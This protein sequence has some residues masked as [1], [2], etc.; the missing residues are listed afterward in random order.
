[1]AEIR[2]LQS[3][4]TSDGRKIVGIIPYNSD[5]NVISERGRKF[6]E[7]I[8]PGAFNRSLEQPPLGDITAHYTHNEEAMPPLGRTS[9]GTLRLSGN[10]EI[11]LRF[12]IDLPQW[13][14]H[15]RESVQR[16]DIGG[17]SFKM[18]NIAYDW[19]RRGDM[20]VGTIRSADLHHIALVLRPAYPGSHAAVRSAV[21]VPD[22]NNLE[23]VALKL[24]LCE[25]DTP[26]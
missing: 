8:H 3:D 6:V 16:G 20:P 19:S 7:R 17:V 21:I 23:L 15:I 9:S 2:S 24:R 14:D 5:S 18:G 12:W 13:A 10:D 1:M 11:G 4:L 22:T 26:R 25:I